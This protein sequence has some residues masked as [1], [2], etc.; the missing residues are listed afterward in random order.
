MEQSFGRYRLLE[1]L[2]EGGMA[3][4]FKAKSFGVEGFEKVL[5][6]KR[7]LPKLAEHPKFVDM[8]VHEAKLAV[9]LS[10]ANIVQ[11]FDLGRVDHPTGDPTSFFIAMEYV[12]GLDLA[13]LLGRCRRHKREVPLG[14]AVFV[15]A[16]VAKALDH[17]HR[18]R[19]EQAKP[20]GIVHR[21]ISPQNVLVSWEG[22]VK[23]TDFGIAKAIDS[24][25]DESADQDAGRVRGKLAYMSPEQSRA[26]DVDGR[27]DIFSLGTVLYEMITGQNPFTAP[28]SFETLRRIQA[29]EYPPIELYRPDAPK[30]VCDILKKMLARD[31]KDRPA[32]AGRLHDE[33]LGFFYAAGARFG[34]ND[35]AEFLTEFR[36]T[37]AAQELAAS[38]FEDE[39]VAA[40]ERTP[41]E[42]PRGGTGQVR[43]AAPIG[44]STPTKDVVPAAA[45]RPAELGQRR[46]VTALVLYA[47][48]ERDSD[49]DAEASARA[50]LTRART[51]LLRYGATI[52]ETESTQ[53]TA[54]FGVAEADGR[55]TE[56]AVRSALLVQRARDGGASVSAGVHVARIVV[57]SQGEPVHDQRLASLVA[58]A[59]SLARVADN[60]VCVSQLAARIVRHA[61]T[62]EDVPVSG[63]NIPEG[64]RLVVSARPPSQMYG[65]FVGRVEELRKLGDILAAATRRKA[66]VAILSGDKGIGKTRLIAEME[67][68]LQKG[69][70]NVGFYTAACPR[71]GADVPWSGLTT[72]LQ[73]L[74]GI[75]E[76]DDEAKIR[77]VL[78]RLRA[79]GLQD[80]ECSAVLHQLG[81]TMNEDAVSRRPDRAA[82]VTSAA[83]RSAFGRMVQSL[84]DD[85]LHVFAWDD[86]HA[87]DRATLDAIVA[88]GS[89][90]PGL[91]AVFLLTARETL[92]ESMDAAHLKRAQLAEAFADHP[93]LHEIALAQLGD[94]DTA[95]FVASRVSAK[96]VPSE[97]LS[98]CRERAGGH[99]LFLE[100]LLK[101]LSDSG[102]I[103]TQSG[104][105]RL[106]LD[107][108]LAVPRSLRA[109]I[110]GRVAR[111][112]A[113]LRPVI[114]GAAVLGEP[115]PIEVLAVLLGQKV[116]Q[117]DR[118]VAA[119]AGKDLLRPI[120]PALA[121]FASP[122]HGEIVL[123]L[124]PPEG[125]RELH[126]AAAAAYTTVF[127]EEAGDYAERAAN[128][129]YEA[130]DRDRAASFYARAALHKMR[131]GLLEPTI[132]LICRAL[133]L[134]DYERRSAAELA[135]WLGTLGAAVYHV[136]RAPELLDLTRRALVRIDA[137]GSRDERL[138]ARIDVARALGSANLFEDCYA[139]LAEA[140]DLA[141]DDP[142]A[143]EHR[144]RA[145]LI[146]GESAL[147]GGDFTRA[148][149]TVEKLEAM[150]PV[151]H[152]RV[153]LAI[154][155]TRGVMGQYERALTVLDRADALADP[156]DLASACNRAKMRALVYL[157]CR[158]NRAGIEASLNAVQLARNA[159]LR[160]D[161]A[162]T[163]HNLGEAARRIGDLPRA[164]AALSE[165]LEVARAAGNERLVSLNR[166]H[167]AFL[168]GV[169][170]VA[171][172]ED[173]LRDLVRYSN[174]HG[175]WTDA[176][177]GRYLLGMLLLHRGSK[178]DAVRELQEVQGLAAAK[179]NR[180]ILEDAREALA[181]I[182]RP[183][184]A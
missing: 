139:R 87:I 83:L 43:T 108:A 106:R 17:A 6:I 165:S 99:P 142:G 69:S 79:L 163:L 4:V 119:L 151:D 27:S 114:Q 11:V 115:V 50:L 173:L 130:G 42:V 179:G 88:A 15:A 131:L 123:D 23:V 110:A 129:L 172:A 66:Q 105:L 126:A 86:A 64:G 140:F 157:Y 19:D 133:D 104:G 121:G 132:A 68:R 30:A 181:K 167:L 9:R 60:S 37:S 125:R 46:E 96:V 138:A 51:V 31:P 156:H 128:H 180:L 18:R 76:G 85:R 175:Y 107:G 39:H 170:G 136:R 112:P 14:M 161:I 118:S 49:R 22:E 116:S 29:S 44:G 24:I 95:K 13:S 134:A 47:G 12:P 103:G 149:R 91:R 58:T 176:L 40:N 111:L 164:Y 174:A 25:V 98:F 109:L 33:L 34:A 72:M 21:D 38:V 5:V 10:H 147:R 148:E 78:P 117:V 55:D 146:E 3:E 36:D 57:D 92:D 52:L 171:G 84:C 152:E 182:E 74:C 73:V 150:G 71:A 101:E 67:R 102:A 143:L 54:I 48:T 82:L 8:F 77:E 158:D 75:Q 26:G 65:R 63:R 122:T 178:E 56:S 20:L 59:Q 28:T 93:H 120:G 183:A 184:G 153:L 162:A 61:F 154:A 70:Y 97:L 144:R 166:I 94:E 90:G 168:D 89:R 160:Y 35:L 159:N 141:G 1:R 145:L 41:V 32:D 53:L 100:E 169:S 113:E 127:G 177:E 80:D 155:F 2:G 81:A 137:V 16:E 124:L 45:V 62:T 135:Q 7:I